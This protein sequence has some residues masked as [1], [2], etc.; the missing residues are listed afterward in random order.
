[1]IESQVKEIE[2]FLDDVKHLRVFGEKFLENTRK[3]EELD[4]YQREK[5]DEIRRRDKGLS[6]KNPIESKI[7]KFKIPMNAWTIYQLKIIANDMHKPYLEL[8]TKILTEAIEEEWKRI[9]PN[10]EKK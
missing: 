7:I 10:L 3:L 4:E 9:R 8:C 6:I 2:E 1:M 5:K